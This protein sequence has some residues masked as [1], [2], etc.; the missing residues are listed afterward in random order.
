MRTCALLLA[1]AAAVAA[2]AAQGQARIEAAPLVT[3]FSAGRPGTALPAPWE[4]FRIARGKK[5]TQYDLVDDQ[6]TIV[7]HARADAAASALR[8]DT[9]FDLHAAPII[10]FRWKISRLIDDQDNAIATRE[11]SPVRVILE[12][13]GDRSKLSLRDRAALSLGD[14][15][16]GREVPYATLIYIWSGAVPV[17]TVIPNPHTGRARMIVATA[18]AT[19]VGSWERVRRNALDDFRKAFGE[20][21]GPM[22]GVAVLSDTDNTG[23]S[24]EGWYGDIR[25][26][27]P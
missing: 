17:G 20:D 25:F 19:R 5:P 26:G 23:E 21:P 3:P 27:A 16:A 11:D 15:I 22:T 14:S 10:E 18:G 9:R 4:P 24:V 8:H 7:L 13:Q 1:A 2:P 12:F 6:G